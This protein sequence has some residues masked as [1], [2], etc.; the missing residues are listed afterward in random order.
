MLHCSCKD[1]L[2]SFGFSY[3]PLSD[4]AV[5]GA[6]FF[7]SAASKRLAD[8]QKVCGLINSV[9]CNWHSFNSANMGSSWDKDVPFRMVYPI[10]C[11]A[12]LALCQISG[13]R[14]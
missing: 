4:M 10:F 1:R 14:Q 9:G 2:I 5:S 6:A 11:S 3:V 13:R 12:H 8:A 7:I